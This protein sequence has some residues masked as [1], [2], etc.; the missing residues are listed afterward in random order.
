M[1]KKTETQKAVI[2]KRPELK[3]FKVGG[4]GVISTTFSTILKLE[5]AK[6]QISALKNVRVK[7]QEKV[8]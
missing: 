2:V 3:K 1:T 4:N 5:T 7:Q 8:A 6:D